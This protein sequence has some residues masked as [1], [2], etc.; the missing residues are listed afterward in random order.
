MRVELSKYE[1]QYVLGKGW[2]T[3]WKYPSEETLRATISNPII[4]KPDKNLVFEKQDLLSIEDHINLFLHC[5]K[6]YKDRLPYRRYDQV[7]F[8]GIIKSYTRKDGSND[9]GVFPIAQS[10]LHMEFEE[11]TEYV[12]N[13][14]EQYDNSSAEMLL[15]LERNVKPYILHLEDELDEA[16]DLL[17]TFYHNYQY[18][19]SEIDNW[20]TDI[21]HMCK[22]IRVIHSNRYLRRRCKLK[23]NLAKSIPEFVFDSL[24]IAQMRKRKNS[25]NKKYPL[26]GK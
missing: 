5:P 1:E 25:I 15:H 14:L 10:K 6:I 23:E 24:S 3:D 26:K 7:T 20:K 22:L 18:Y 12:I 8:A 13:L 16:G 11:M 9:W 21:T 19:K 2:I 4:K 17:P